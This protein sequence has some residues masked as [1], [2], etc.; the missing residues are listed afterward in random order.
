M[1]PAKRPTMPWAGADIVQSH[2][3][4]RCNG[5]KGRRRAPCACSAPASSEDGPT[6]DVPPKCLAGGEV[7]ALPGPRGT[8]AEGEGRDPPPRHGAG[9]ACRSRSERHGKSLPQA[10]HA[11]CR[12]SD[13]AVGRRGHCP[14][15]RGSSLQRP[16]GRE[17]RTLRLF[18][19]SIFERPPTGD[20]PAKCLAG[21]EARALPGPRGT[22]GRRGGARPAATPRS[23]SCLPTSIGTPR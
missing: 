10:S 14:I 19:A 23:R 12:A 17:A 8:A 21:G 4:V 18:G 13:N 6:G 2:A 1:R 16:E 3:G 5:R 7:R 20:A 11:S 9:L 15:A 22:G